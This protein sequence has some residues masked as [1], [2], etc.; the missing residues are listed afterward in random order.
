M[1]S[2]KDHFPKE[3]SNLR[4]D[5]L[6]SVEHDIARTLRTIILPYFQVLDIFS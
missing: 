5:L 3:L 1:K 4:V 2:N 6:A